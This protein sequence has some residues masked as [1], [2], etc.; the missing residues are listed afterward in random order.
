M[1]RLLPLLAISALALAASA[2]DKYKAQ[3][4]AQQPSQ[5]PHTIQPDWSKAREYTA[6]IKDALSWDLL[7]QAELMDLSAQGKPKVSHTGEPG[8]GGV[9]GTPPEGDGTEPP[10]FEVVFSKELQKL[11]GKQV[12]LAGFMLPLQQAEAHKTFLL[13]AVPPSCPFCLPGGP[14]TTVH[15]VCKKPLKY[16][17]DAVVLNGTME[18]LKDDPSGFYY[19]LADAEAQ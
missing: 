5:T 4:P 15:V 3:T 17:M 18:L 14:N 9:F 11:Q 19:R 13:S 1:R 10:K 12:K 6:S 7:Q 16:S 8:K 2:Q